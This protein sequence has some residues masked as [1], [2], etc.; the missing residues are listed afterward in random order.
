MVDEYATVGARYPMTTKT[1]SRTEVESRVYKQYSEKAEDNSKLAAHYGEI[2]IGMGVKP[3]SVPPNLVSVK[4]TKEDS[5]ATPGSALV[6]RP[7]AAGK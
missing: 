1:I 4:S 2:L 7:K 5:M 6:Q 3:E